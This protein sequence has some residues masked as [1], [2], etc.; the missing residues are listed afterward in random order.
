MGPL[1]NRH[2]ITFV[3]KKRES[4]PMHMTQQREAVLSCI[5]QAVS[6]K[7]AMEIYIDLKS[8]MT[9]ISLST[10][11]CSLK[12]FVKNNIVRELDDDG[13][14]KRYEYTGSIYREA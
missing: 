10:V 14:S 5:N 4:K 9:R 6:P 8:D 12:Y 11:Y 1:N 2:M 3:K 7:T 13:L